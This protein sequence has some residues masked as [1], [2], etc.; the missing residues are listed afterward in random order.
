M[1]RKAHR[2][3][4]R[5]LAHDVP[6]GSDEPTDPTLDD[7]TNDLLVAYPHGLAVLDDGVLGAVGDI[8]S[9]T[10]QSWI[11]RGFATVERLAKLELERRRERALFHEARR[12]LTA[13]APEVAARAHATLRRLESLR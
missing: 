1:I 11:D 9:A 12:Q 2:L 5:W 13:A 8:P 3:L 10:L 4:H 6:D 7:E